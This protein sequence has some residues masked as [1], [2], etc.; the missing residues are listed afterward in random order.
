LPEILPDHV[1]SETVSAS[2]A[3]TRHTTLPSSWSHAPCGGYF[4]SPH[5]SNLSMI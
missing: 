2:G 4:G 3:Q 1:T 5:M